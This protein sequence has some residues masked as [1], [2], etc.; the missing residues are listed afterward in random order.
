MNS[1]TKNIKRI[2]LPA[3]G[4]FIAV[5]LAGCQSSDKSSSENKNIADKAFVEPGEYDEYYGFLSGGYSGQL[6]VYGIPSGRH[7]Y[8]IPVFSESPTNG[9]GYSEETKALLNTSYG[10]VPWGDLHHPELSQ[11]DG[12]PDGR[13]VF[14]NENNT[15]RIA[16]IDLKTFRTDEIIELPN[17]GG[18]HASPFVTS[19][20]EY[21]F[22]H[23]RF[24]IPVGDNQDVPI[25]SYSENLKG[26]VSFIKV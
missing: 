22:G 13:W 19:N 9:Y 4:L 14:V 7:L 23:S 26:A 15:P 6:S 24:A 16:R 21:V 10:K 3:L 17:T 5:G 12:K 2:L 20:T 11:T 1:L 18:N 25:D 8:T